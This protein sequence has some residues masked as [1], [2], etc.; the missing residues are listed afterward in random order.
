MPGSTSSK[1]EKS[2]HEAKKNRENQSKRTVRL[3]RAVPKND[4]WGH[5]GGWFQQHLYV[6]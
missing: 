3:A 4:A 2:E 5:S 6:E 1:R